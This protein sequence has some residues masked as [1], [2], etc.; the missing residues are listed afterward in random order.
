M[1][2]CEHF[3]RRRGLHP[4][5]YSVLHNNAVPVKKKN[6]VPWH[7]TRFKTEICPS[8]QGSKEKVCQSFKFVASCLQYRL[9]WGS[10]ILL[11]LYMALACFKLD[12]VCF[13]CGAARKF[14]FSFSTLKRHMTSWKYGIMKDMNLRGRLPLFIQN[15]LSESKLRVRV[16]TS[17]TDF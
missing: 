12:C 7:F 3:C 6:K 9:G 10:Y 13:I 4:D 2:A 16:G 17:L 15:F 14:Y 5:P 8:Y 1:T 11:W